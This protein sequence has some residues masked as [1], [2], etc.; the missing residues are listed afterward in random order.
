MARRQ[1]RDGTL[2]VDERERTRRVAVM[3]LIDSFR[4]GGSES[5]ALNLYLEMKESRLFDPRLACLHRSGALLLKLPSDERSAVPEFKLNSF[6]DVQMAHQLCS[7]VRL[8]RK[9]AIRV[10]HTHD[11]YTNIFGMIGAMLAGVP[12]RVASRRE[13]PKRP[14]IKRFVERMAYRVSNAVIA[15]CDRI[16]RDLLAEGVATEKIITIY[17]GVTYE[18]TPMESMGTACPASNGGVVTIVANLRPVKDHATFLRAARLVVERFPR[19]IFMLAGDGELEPHLR[20]MAS[21]LGI[22]D[23]V[24]FIGR[25]D[26]VPGLLDRSNVC[27]LSSASEGF[28]N[29][30]L[31]YM[32][33]GRPVVAT[34]VGGIEEAVSDGYNGFLVDPGD[35]VQMADRIAL[36]LESPGGAR[37]MGSRSRDIV[38]CKFSRRRQLQRVEQLYQDLLVA[39]APEQRPAALQSKGC[40]FEVPSRARILRRRHHPEVR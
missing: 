24:R 36:L 14:R 32:A 7:F 19:S 26:D 37:E 1:K 13:A 35:Y 18:P 31:E 11:F 38:A 9:D 28:S 33:A 15:N 40:S 8:L 20:E 30:V 23:R 21:A 5:Q 22:G 27:V 3:H 12:I 6:Y 4:L 25:C 29:A 39:R 16:R 10:V 17:N 34:R 2:S